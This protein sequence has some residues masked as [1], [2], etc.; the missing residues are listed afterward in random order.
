MSPEQTAGRL[1]LMGPASDVYSLGATLYA[2]LTGTA[3][4]ADSDVNLVIQRVLR[5]QSVGC[6]PKAHHPHSS[7]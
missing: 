2:L 7:G 3:P 4:F 5:G 6:V 1:S